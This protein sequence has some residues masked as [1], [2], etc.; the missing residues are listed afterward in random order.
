MNFHYLGT[1]F[2]NPDDLLALEPEELA[3]HLLAQLNSLGAHSR[4]CRLDF[5]TSEQLSAAWGV[6]K[7]ACH[8]ALM[9]AWTVLERESL[10]APAPDGGLYFVTRRG[11]RLKTVADYATFR[12]STLFPRSAIHPAIE[13]N[14][15][16]EFLRGDYE[17]AVFKAFREVEIAVKAAASGLDPKLYG[18]DLMRKAFHPENGPLTDPNEPPAE[19]EALLALF[20]GAIGRFKNPPSHRHVPL[21]S[22][23]ETVEL[24][25]FAS[26]LLRVVADRS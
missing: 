6:K 7:V 21:T 9:E 22:P 25:Q 11:Q 1:A 5:H 16:S 2:A 19:R 20:A 14:V 10:I 8:Q 3:G 26:H 17:S 13:Q 18:I 12:H 4:L 23:Q 15:Y 24:L